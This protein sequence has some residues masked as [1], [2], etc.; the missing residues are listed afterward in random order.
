MNH[1]HP[2][3]SQ[4]H[5]MEGRNLILYPDGIRRECRACKYRRNAAQR[6]SRREERQKEQKHMTLKALIDAVQDSK[7]SAD[8]VVSDLGRLQPVTRLVAGANVVMLI[9]RPRPAWQSDVEPDRP[10]VK[11]LRAHDLIDHALTVAAL[12]APEERRKTEAERIS[13]QAGAVGVV[14]TYCWPVQGTVYPTAAQAAPVSTQT[15][16]VQLL[17]ADT[18]AAFT[19]N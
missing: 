19:H 7:I 4:G 14:A 11:P 8:V 1:P 2:L 9:C 13:K 17:D 3:C 16:L 10:N 5:P 15:A 6:K 12:N 18:Q